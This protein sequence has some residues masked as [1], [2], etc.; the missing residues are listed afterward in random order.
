MKDI[1]QAI[2]YVLTE[3]PQAVRR[4]KGK[5]VDR[6]LLVIVI[7]LALF[8]VLMVYNT[9]VAIA[10][11]DFGD[12]HFFIRDQLVWFI[13]GII[14]CYV[15]SRIEYKFWY[16][17]AVPFLILSL[18]LLVAVF[19]PVVGMNIYGASRWLNL[20]I[21]TIQPSEVAKLAVCVYLAAWLS[22]KEK[23]R[24]NAFILFL[25]L[26][27]GLV[28][29]Q[30]DMG[31]SIILLL[32]SVSVYLV[33]G[34]P[35]KHILKLLP[36][37]IVIF[38][39]LAIAAPYRL[40]RI[41][42]FFQPNNDPLGSSYQIR[43]AIL[44]I[45][46]GGW[47]GVGIGKSRQK[48]EYL[49]EANTDSIFAIVAEEVGFIGALIILTLYLVVIFR[50]F[51]IAKHAP[52]T[53]SRLIV[54]GIVSWFGFQS[55]INIGAIVKLMPLTGVPLPLISSGGSSFMVLMIAFGILLNIS[56]YRKT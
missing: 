46:S 52:D 4:S 29:L 23:G 38:V 50:G 19:F 7:G 44:A 2:R 1:L 49:P 15:F 43:Q 6:L 42:T 14:C 16:P 24:F 25:G 33:S 37:A 18:I 32:M 11:R 53:F 56:R 3:I 12:P 35:F 31:T 22:H 45:G 54:V 36:I 55:A 28:L 13:F 10:L 26:V 48:Y 34:A 8:G 30:P 27:V 5:P 40:E 41:T 20:G 17:T 9:S 51:I 47:T 39:L 21:I